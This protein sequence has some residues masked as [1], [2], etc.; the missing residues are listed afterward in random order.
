MKTFNVAQGYCHKVANFRI[1][2]GAFYGRD[3]ISYWYCINKELYPLDT[4]TLEIYRF[5]PKD[6]E[7]YLLIEQSETVNTIVGCATKEDWD[8]PIE[9]PKYTGIHNIS[10]N[11]D[12]TITRKKCQAIKNGTKQFGNRKENPNEIPL[13]LWETVAPMV[14]S[15]KVGNKTIKRPRWKKTQYIEKPY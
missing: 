12:K 3:D 11:M 14:Y 4:P 5:N 7:W 1:P 6:E 8:M 9:Y 2:K 10:A 15:E 13:D